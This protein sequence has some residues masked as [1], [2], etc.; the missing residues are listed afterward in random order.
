MPL[1]RNSGRHPCSVA[2]YPSF[3]K[4][5]MNGYPTPERKFPPPPPLP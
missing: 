3:N 4:F 2:G 5:R 1:P